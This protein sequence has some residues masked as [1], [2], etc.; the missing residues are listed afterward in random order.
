MTSDQLVRR[1]LT[2]AGE[3]PFLAAAV[4]LFAAQQAAIRGLA[5]DGGAGEIRRAIFFPST[6]CLAILALHFRSWIGA[7]A[8]A[9]GIMLNLVPMAAHGGL[10]PVS[11]AVVEQSGAFPEITERDLGHQ[12]GNGKDV[13]LADG[14]IRFEPLSDRYV[15]TL[16]GYGTNIYSLGDFVLF[17]GV[18]LVL[19]QA[20]W[21][22][23]PARRRRDPDCERIT[24]E[25][26]RWCEVEVVAPPTSNAP[27]A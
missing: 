20:G 13:L 23:F 1:R 18:G 7:W 27:P 12:L 10:M 11:Y 19:L 9:A 5:L 17:A 8:I 26:V 14:E 2:G 15:V 4:A 6:I 16:P 22:A 3:L 21:E 25:E 24:D